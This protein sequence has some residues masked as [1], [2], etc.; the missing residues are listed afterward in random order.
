MRAVSPAS[1]VVS[2]SVTFLAAPAALCGG[3]GAPGEPPRAPAPPA[4][5]EAAP[6]AQIERAAGPYRLRIDRSRQV[7]ALDLPEDREFG[8]GEGPQEAPLAPTLRE[9]GAGAFV[10]A[11]ALAQKAKLFDD[12]LLAAVEIAAQRGAGRF[13]GKARIVER[14]AARAPL[15]ELYAAAALG[16]LDLGAPPP[17]ARVAERAQA[18]LAEFRADPRRSKPLGFYAWTPELR[19]IF[20]QDRMLQTPIEGPERIAALGAA[21]RADAELRAAYEAYLGLVARLTNPFPPEVLDLRA[22]A[23]AADTAAGAEEG[24]GARTAAPL[25]ERVHVFPPSRSHEAELA[26]RLFGNRPIPEGFQLLDELIERVRAGTLDLAPRADSGWYDRVAWALEPLAAPERA[27]E[28]ARLALSESYR[29]HLEDLSKAILALARETHVKQLELPLAGSAIPRP[30]LDVDPD[31]ATEPLAT[32]YL[33]RALAYRFVRGALLAAFGE[34]AL[35]ELRRPGPGGAPPS[36]DAPGLLEEL[37]RMESLFLGAYLAT[38][39]DIGLAPDAAAVSA[40]GPGGAS[41]AHLDAFERW[42]REHAADPDLAQDARMMVPLF[43]DAGR[44]KTKVALFLGWAARP[45]R[46]RFA[47]PPAVEIFD[48]AGNRVDPGDAGLRF[49][50]QTARIAYPAVAETYV[51]RLL[52]RDEFRALCDRKKTRAAILTALERDE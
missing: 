50:A 33:R 32:H 11:S 18:L 19:A 23:A 31:L 42:A 44:K 17:D 38:C 25:P 29:K 3:G 22:A 16:G 39:R 43:Y 37:A 2:A 30:S 34:E 27:P 46:I 13:P 15:A 4:G 1:L 45:L 48:A 36:P 9:A 41:A 52:D 49:R 7:L 28:G 26:K 24:A 21:L 14:L 40:G 51:T 8:E 5:P 6:P 47:E 10:S 20:Q 35:A 12:G